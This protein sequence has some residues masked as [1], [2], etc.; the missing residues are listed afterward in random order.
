MIKRE[1]WP[2]RSSHWSFMDVKCA[3]IKQVKYP[4][5][6]EGGCWVFIGQ[7]LVMDYY[8]HSHKDAKVSATE[9]PQEEQL[10]GMNWDEKE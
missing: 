10:L 2:W 7:V 3:T 8:G 1:T 9:S 4:C 5:K 6:R